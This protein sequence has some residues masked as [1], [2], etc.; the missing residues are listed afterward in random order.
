M[1]VKGILLSYVCS[2][3]ILNASTAIHGRRQSRPRKGAIGMGTYEFFT[4]LVVFTV[5]IMSVKR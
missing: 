5:L 2:C 1:C 4:F 3:A